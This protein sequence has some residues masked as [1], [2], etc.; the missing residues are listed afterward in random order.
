MERFSQQSNIF[1]RLIQLLF[2]NSALIFRIVIYLTI[3]GL[4][5]WLQRNYDFFGVLIGTFRD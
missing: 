1:S 3:A 2:A 4:L 5:I